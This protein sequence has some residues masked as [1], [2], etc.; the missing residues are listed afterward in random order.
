T[1]YLVEEAAKRLGLSQYEKIED[2]D[3]V[4]LQYESLYDVP[5]QEGVVH[6]VVEWDLVDR[7]S[8]SGVV[9][10]APGCGEEDFQLGKE[11]DAPALAPLDTKGIFI[12]GYGDLTG[13][14]A[15][16]VNELVFEYLKNR[17]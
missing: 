11:L 17:G 6:K 12:D 5:A 14:Y 8:G 10:V 4:G 16:D 15:H 9:H 7:V 1:L 2:A 13:K 3:L